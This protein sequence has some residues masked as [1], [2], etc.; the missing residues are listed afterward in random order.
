MKTER[1]FANGFESWTDAHAEICMAIGSRL[2]ADKLNPIMADI[3]ERLGRCGFWAKAFDL[4]NQFETKY[5]WVR[6]GQDINPATL[7]PFD[8]FDTLD[9]F[10]NENLGE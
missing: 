6:F 8:Y 4:T 10:I 9:K 3:Q 7:E 1:D 2:T 5:E